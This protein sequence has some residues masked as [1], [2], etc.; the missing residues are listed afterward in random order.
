[1]KICRV[2]KIEKEESD[3]NKKNLLCKLCQKDYNRKYRQDNAKRIKKRA[4]D[5]YQKNKEENEREL[6]RHRKEEYQKNR[7]KILKQKKEHYEANKDKMHARNKRNYIKNREKLLAYQVQYRLE[8]KD[9]IS[10]YQ[11]QYNAQNKEKI[12]ERN[13]AYERKR[14][15][16]DP[17]YR[18]RKLI[19]GKIS[20]ILRQKN[21][22]KGGVSITKHLPYTMEQLKKHLEQ[23]FEPW[24]NW[25]NQGIYQIA[26]CDENDQSTWKWQIDHI[27]PE[28]KLPY[29]SMEDENFHKAWAL[30]NL[31]PLSAKA[32]LEK[33][34]KIGKQ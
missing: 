6:T 12:K 20:S 4:K 5:N 34:D 22:S 14:S 28:S 18:L 33:S 32:N 3:F 7:E 9:I 27:Y 13:R 11:E 30:S 19:R 16:K 24:M 15:K 26:T 21:L 31:Q 1:M 10:E 2:C 23:Q 17:V 29:S 8:N 25:N